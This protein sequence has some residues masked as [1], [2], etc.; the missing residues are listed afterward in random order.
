MTHGRMSSPFWRGGASAAPPCPEA[1]PA[2][3]RLTGFHSYSRNRRVVKGN[4]HS[5]ASRRGCFRRRRLSFRAPMTGRAGS[6]LRAALAP[7]E[8]LRF[9]SLRSLNLGPCT[10]PGRCVP[11]R[12]VV[13]WGRHPAVGLAVW[14]LATTERIRQQQVRA[15]RPHHGETDRVTATGPLAARH[16]SPRSSSSSRSTSQRTFSR[17]SIASRKTV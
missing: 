7:P 6:A 5:Q 2:R 17:S 4:A 15:R 8:R 14:K 9:R 16:S 13:P 12:Q 10:V 3:E 1:S 11:G